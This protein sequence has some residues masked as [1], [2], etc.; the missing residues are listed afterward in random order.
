MIKKRIYAIGV[1]FLALYA[2]VHAAAQEE[3]DTQICFNR[4]IKL[5][6][7]TPVEHPLNAIAQEIV[8]EFLEAPGTSLTIEWSYKNRSYKYFPT[9]DKDKALLDQVSQELKGRINPKITKIRVKIE[10]REWAILKYR[11]PLFY[12]L[13]MVFPNTEELDCGDIIFSYE[14]KDYE[15]FPRFRTLRSSILSTGVD[16]NVYKVS[17]RQRHS[18][19][20]LCSLTQRKELL[21][22]PKFLQ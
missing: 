21:F 12:I 9:W 19:D 3:S 14:A 2:S 13:G 5:R 1:V 6:E 11:Q 8:K 17:Q 22:L 7:T 20:Q 16:T 15:V 4:L 18:N 10:P